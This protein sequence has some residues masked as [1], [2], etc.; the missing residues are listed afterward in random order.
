MAKYTQIRSH[1]PSL[2]RPE[3]GDSGLLSIFLRAVGGVLDGLDRDLAAVMQAHWLP[4][5]D[6]ARF[7][8]YFLR[9]RAARGLGAPDPAVG[10]DRRAMASFPYLHDL[11]RLG[12]LLSLPPWREPPELRESVEAYR[13]RLKRFVALYRN[14]L[15]TVKALRAAVEA[16]LPPD[17]EQP[18]EAVER[19]FAVEEFTPIVTVRQKARSLGNLQDAD[20]QLKRLGPLMRWQLSNDGL[21]AAA[22]TVYIRAEAQGGAERPMIE[23]FTAGKTWQTSVGIAWRGTLAKGQTLRLRPAHACWLG[24]LDGLWQSQSLPT[25]STPADAA[26]AGPW[27]TVGGAPT[28]PITAICQSADHVLWAAAV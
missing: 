19:S 26:A 16:E 20:P 14:G 6:Q 1:L 15:G 18:P 24:R 3:A 10:D 5:A 21:A 2:Y 17:P 13:T 8:P 28:A 25:E 9:E 7:D 4:V 27:T 11:A 22:P 23:T 12:A